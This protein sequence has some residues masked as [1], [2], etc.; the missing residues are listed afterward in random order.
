MTKCTLES[1]P[2]LPERA[3]SAILRVSSTITSVGSGAA[4][5]ASQHVFQHRILKPCFGGRN[6]QSPTLRRHPQYT[7]CDLSDPRRPRVILA[8]NFHVQVTDH[9][10]HGAATAVT[11]L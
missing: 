11:S 8:L 10:G 6:S 4:A 1:S 2:S 9:G 7:R 5:P 3:C